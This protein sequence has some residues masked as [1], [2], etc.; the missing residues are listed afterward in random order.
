MLI[1]RGS[2][3]GIVLLLPFAGFLIG[4]QESTNFWDAVIDP[5]YAIFSILACL[6][7]LVPR[8]K[9]LQGG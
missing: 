4:L 6:V 5:F 3:F 9:V 2:R 1:L 7:L 8:R